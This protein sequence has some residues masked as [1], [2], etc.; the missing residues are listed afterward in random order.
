MKGRK[1]TALFAL[2][3]IA[4]PLGAIPTQG[5]YEAPAGGY[6][7]T[8]PAWWQPQFWLVD[9]KKSEI[10]DPF[11]YFVIYVTDNVTSNQYVISEF[12]APVQPN[13]TITYNVDARSPSN[14]V[15][16][17]ILASTF[18]TGACGSVHISPFIFNETDLAWSLFKPVRIIFR[19]YDA[20]TGAG[21]PFEQ[22]NVT[23]Q[24]PAQEG[25]SAS[26]E[27]PVGLGFLDLSY[28]VNMT[29]RV[30]D[31]FGNLLYNQTRIF[32]AN[33]TEWCNPGFGGSFCPPFVRGTEF[34]DIPL[35]VYS[36]KFYNQKP[37]QFV[38]ITLHWNGTGTGEEMYG[39]PSSGLFPPW[40]DSAYAYRNVLLVNATSNVFVGFDYNLS[41]NLTPYINAGKMQSDMRDLRVVFYNST[42]G[43]WEEVNRTYNSTSGKLSFKAKANLTSGSQSRAYFLYY[44]NNLAL[45]P[46]TFI[47]YQDL[48]LSTTG[49]R[50][51]WPMDEPSGSTFQDISGAADNCAIT[52]SPT[53][54]VLGEVIKGT[55]WG[56]AGSD[57]ANCPSGM[58]GSTFSIEG[59]YRGTTTPAGQNRGIISDH[60]GSGDFDF[61][62]FIT[63]SNTVNC[64]VK[65][66]LG[67]GSVTTGFAILNAVWYH[68]GCS[69]DGT[70]VRLYINGT[71]VTPSA[72]ITGTFPR[73]TQEILIGQNG[74]S[75]AELTGATDSWGYYNNV[76]TQAQMFARYEAGIGQNGTA[77]VT[78][79]N[80]QGFEWYQSP[81]ET[82]ER[83]LNPGYYSTRIATVNTAGELTVVTVGI[84]VTAAN[85][86]MIAGLNITHFV[87]DF[88]TISNQ[89]IQISAALRPDIIHVGT[90]LP[91]NPSELNGPNL[92]DFSLIHPFS[93]LTG[94]QG[95]TTP[96]S[97]T[98]ATA[99]APNLSSDSGD[100]S[101]LTTINVL[102]D[103]YVF[104]GSATAHVWINS[105]NGT[106]I[107]EN[108][109]LPPMVTLEGFS[110]DVF[111]V[112]NQSIQVTR[113]SD[114]RAIWEFSFRYYPSFK[115]YEQS[116]TL[117][118][119]GNRTVLNPKWFVG[120]PDPAELEGRTI[121]VST[122]AV[123]DI[124]NNIWLKA[125]QH[126]EV[127][128][129]GYYMSFDQLNATDERAFFF[130]FYDENGTAPLSTQILQVTEVIPASFGGSSGYWLGS[131]TFAN[132][133]GSAYSGD[134]I[135]RMVCS[136]QCQ[137]I[138]L[139]TVQVV[140]H[141]AGR[142]LAPNEYF[143]SEQGILIVG[144][145]VG[146]VPGGSSKA[147]DIYFK[148]KDTPTS[149]SWCCFT[150][151]LPAYLGPLT[152]FHV[153]L[154]LTVASL[155]GGITV[156]GKGKRAEDWRSFWM[157][158]FYV[159]AMI[160]A[161]IFIAHGQ[162]WVA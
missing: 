114:F 18:T 23:V 79:D 81:G 54:G 146:S 151:L 22:F 49:I 142:T 34:W 2:C 29:I 90:L 141:V 86:Y 15:P 76:L 70:N 106:T 105:T 7:I 110:G 159:F 78:L 157:A 14:D 91:R 148:V 36:T 128:T 9:G 83:F 161:F 61:Y 4:L 11:E 40:W 17:S 25:Y 95:Y 59:W 139:K 104:S 94:T 98:N 39:G 50:A 26:P 53:R 155:V 85:F 21:L 43:T 41:I 5:A 12:P 145:S 122:A 116:L 37:D 135:I 69:Y 42:P 62:T 143:Q 133:F 10:L 52:G 108:A 99:F 68:I 92:G 112:S 130:T 89:Q 153:L 129:S 100:G 123:K 147:Y 30:R 20:N 107:W 73:L 74:F 13:A 121:N 111:V 158:G 48:V 87:G 71:E 126:F 127:G 47:P 58:V 57:R 131:A 118:N 84:N 32:Y 124:D 93:I 16:G 120:F 160:S 156:T 33:T 31:F 60:W 102:K 96:T 44:G 3:L 80:S 6:D 65:T 113:I 19:L 46:P 138:D 75:S 51:Y 152:F 67:T 132:G 150:P 125:G 103:Q 119:T 109:T 134:L 38:K 1:L 136:P 55:D 162:G 27:T 101:L 63:T 64:Q 154:I 117:N 82:V 144:S 8:C 77:N 66:N 45:S 28:R 24:F 88:I 140:D 97:A 137:Q 56:G 35:T 115:R 149:T 72:S